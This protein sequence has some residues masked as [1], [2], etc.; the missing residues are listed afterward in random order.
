[1]N[2]NN[3]QRATEVSP[4]ILRVHLDHLIKGKLVREKGRQGR[5]RGQKLWYTVTSTGEKHAAKEALE[6]IVSATTTM[7]T[8]VN[9]I[10]EEPQKISELRKALEQQSLSYAEESAKKIKMMDRDPTMEEVEEATALFEK[11]NK[12][13]AL[14]RSLK[15]LYHIYLDV[16]L[17]YAFRSDSRSGY[18]EGFVIGI[19]KKGGIYLI[20][21]ASLKKHGL[22]VGL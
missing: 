10:A 19:T 18:K 12:I 1:M 13:G 11:G 7:E 21:V 5:K 8:M 16:A 3:L 9:A 4:R 14:A 15:N 20:P 6:D 2:F 17:P 22:G